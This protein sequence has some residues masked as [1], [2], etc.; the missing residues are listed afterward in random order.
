MLSAAADHPVRVTRGPCLPG[1]TRGRS[2]PG[3]SRRGN[4]AYTT[5][6]ISPQEP[7]GCPAC[8]SG[9][10]VGSEPLYAVTTVRL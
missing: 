10:P 6:F 4:M 8:C 5:S 7:E 2:V 3:S 1:R 9:E